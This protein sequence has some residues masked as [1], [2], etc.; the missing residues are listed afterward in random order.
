MAAA[1][2]DAQQSPE[3]ETNSAKR[4][5]SLVGKMSL[6]ENVDHS[7]RAFTYYHTTTK[8]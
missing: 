3:V 4:V 7:G 1:S 8:H 2:A 6:E 5:D